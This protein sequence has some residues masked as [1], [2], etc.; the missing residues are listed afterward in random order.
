MEEY[1]LWI[2]MLIAFV[3][4]LLYAMMQRRKRTDP[5]ANEATRE[6]YEKDEN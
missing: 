1:W 2:A 6:L 5:A 4:A 3:L